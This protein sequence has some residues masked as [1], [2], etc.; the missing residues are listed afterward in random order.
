MPSLRLIALLSALGLVALVLVW[1]LIGSVLFRR[2]LIRLL[3]QRHP[4][5]WARAM[6]SPDYVDPLAGPTASS[7]RL[8]RLV[9]EAQ[10]SGAEDPELYRRA[11]RLKGASA[12]LIGCILTLVALALASKLWPR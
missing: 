2:Q 10:R 9:A 4:D 11:R 6:E 7:S 12:A 5:I 8:V 3:K 1:G